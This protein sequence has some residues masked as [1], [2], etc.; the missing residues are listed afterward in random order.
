[1]HGATAKKLWTLKKISQWFIGL[2]YTWVGNF[3]TFEGR[4]FFFV[5]KMSISPSLPFF[6]LRGGGAT[7]L[8]S[9]SCPPPPTKWCRN[10][11]TILHYFWQHNPQFQQAKTHGQRVNIDCRF[12]KAYCP[13][14]QDTYNSFIRRFYIYISTSVSRT[15]FIGRI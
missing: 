8:P 13:L 5:F 4:K 9:P 10:H 3:K 6:C 14:P 1:M 2:P 12:G 11:T 7:P 15:I